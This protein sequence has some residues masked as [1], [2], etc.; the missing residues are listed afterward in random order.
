MYVIEH[1]VPD[2][3][4]DTPIPFAELSDEAKEI[5]RENFREHHLDYDW[6]EFCYDD[7]T[8]IAELLGITVKSRQVKMMSGRSYTE[9]VIYFSGFWS[10]GDGACFEGHWST[11]SVD[12]MGILDGIL[13]HAPTDETLHEIALSL[14]DLAERHGT[15]PDADGCTSVSLTHGGTYYHEHSISFDF[16]SHLPECAEEW[17]DFQRMTWEATRRAR[18]MD[19]WEDDV[20]GVMRDLMRWL[21]RQLEQ[22]YEHLNSDT[23][24]DEALADREFLPDGTEA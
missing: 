20:K 3:D 9:P 24:I 12:P 16:E 2:V 19:T 17:N 15:D 7:F 22:E 18:H 11:N 4:E 10:Q 14:A 1:A 6:W 5:A 23:C 21:Y 13:A 8:T